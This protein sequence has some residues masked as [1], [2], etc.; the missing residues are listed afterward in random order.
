MTLPKGNAEKIHAEARELL[1]R[2]GTSQG[3]FIAQDYPDYEAIGANKET[4]R[5]MAEAF[6]QAGREIYGAG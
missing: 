1:S 6:T 2:W 4:M 3:G 5:T